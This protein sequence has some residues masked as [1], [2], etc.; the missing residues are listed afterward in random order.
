M[1]DLPAPTR[2]IEPGL[3]T[4]PRFPGFWVSAGWIV[5]YL[6]L[7]IVCIAVATSSVL[8]AQNL[9]N[10]TAFRDNP[11]ILLWG[12]A[13]AAAVQLLL[14]ALYL[15]RRGRAAQLGLTHFGQM[16]LLPTLG[17]AFAVVVLAML[18]NALYA[19][20]IIPGIRMQG[21]YADLLGKLEMTP[22]HIGLGLFFAVIAAPVV[23]ELLFRGFLQRA[24]IHRLPV[25]AAI[26]LSS[27]GFAIIHGQPY[28][29]P[30]L[31]SLSIAFGYLYYR[32]GSLR[33]NIILHMANNAFALL[34]TLGMG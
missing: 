21:D 18:F 30:G 20:F 29:I 6:T 34:I 9:G 25:W 17:L 26:G 15:A 27:L 22:V 5:L 1:N 28:A 11:Q 24:L 4:S 23:E 16:K 33:T 8:G 13:S 7:Q 14:M 31:M 19:R 32:T 12:G 2:T 3:S 10:V